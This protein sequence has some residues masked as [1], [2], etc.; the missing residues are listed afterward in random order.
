MIATRA[1]SEMDKL[2]KRQEILMSAEDLFIKQD[3][4]F[5]TVNAICT[6]GAMA[7]GTVYI[8]FE[9]KDAI[10]LALLE[11]YFAQWLNLKNIDK[12]PVT[13][14]VVIDSL[15]NFIRKNPYK[16][17]LINSNNFL[18]SSAGPENVSAFYGELKQLFEQFIN[19]I[20]EQM[21]EPV[22]RCT[23]WLLDSYYYLQGLWRVAN[24]SHQNQSVLADSE[25]SLF[26]PEFYSSA[27]SFMK[28]LWEQH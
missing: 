26:I 10:I 12:K 15:L 9:N 11:K 27:E 16:F 18:E 2:D 20:S 21:N 17:Q 6:Y 19:Y 8:Y 5:P 22:E 14:D 4:V 1:Y 3:G 24:P 13:I 25:Y 28:K 23:Q 7:K